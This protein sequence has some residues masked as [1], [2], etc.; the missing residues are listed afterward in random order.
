MY[1]TQISFRKI[2]VTLFYNPN[3]CDDSKAAVQ[4]AV[5]KLLQKFF[6]VYFA[7]RKLLILINKYVLLC[8]LSVAESTEL[9]INTTGTT[10]W[11]FPEVDGT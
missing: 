3:I 10:F 8:I 2:K 11:N 4:Q 6:L 5:S 9:S 1:P 7:L